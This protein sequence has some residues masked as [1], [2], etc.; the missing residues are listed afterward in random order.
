MGFA[1]GLIILGTL[2]LGRWMALFYVLFILVALLDD[3][4]GFN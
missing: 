2:V 1:L 3:C 4:G